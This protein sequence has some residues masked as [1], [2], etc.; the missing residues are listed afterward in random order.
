MLT[1]PPPLPSFPT[2]CSSGLTNRLRNIVF[3]YG[4]VWKPEI[5]AGLMGLPR[6][7]TE[8]LPFYT[9][10]FQAIKSSKN[11][12]FETILSEQ[13]MCSPSS[14]KTAII[15]QDSLSKLKRIERLP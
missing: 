14:V 9:D 4:Q 8:T 6:L 1:P 11:C 15:S 7:V 5:S 10:K 2:P 13:T 3:L 12:R